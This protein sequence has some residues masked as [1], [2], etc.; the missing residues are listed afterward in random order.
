MVDRT[1]YRVASPTNFF[2]SNLVDTVEMRF[3]QG[4]GGIQTPVFLPGLVTNRT[5]LGTVDGANDYL[6]IYDA[7][8]GALKAVAPNNLP[9]GGGG[10]ANTASNTGTGVGLFR[11]KSGIDLVFKSATNSSTRLSVTTNDTHLLLDAVEAN[12][13]LANLG[14]LLGATQLHT[15]A[16]WSQT[17]DTTPDST[18]AILIVDSATASLRKVQIGN[19]PAGAGTVTHTT[20]ALTA[21]LPLTGNG[22][23]D[24]KTNTWAYFRDLADLEPGVDVQV[25]NL[26]LAGI[27]AISANG[28]VARTGS[29]TAAARTFTGTANEIDVSNGN[30]VSGNPVLSLPS[31]INLAAKASV[32][33]PTGATNDFTTFDPGA[34]GFGSNAWAAVRG[35]WRY[36]DGTASN[37]V[38]G[39]LVSDPPSNGQVPKWN[40]GG[41]ITWE[42]D[43]T[44]G[45][46]TF[47]TVAS[48]QNTTASMQ[49][50][51]GATLSVS[52]GEV[53][54]N[55]VTNATVKGAMTFP[56]NVRQT[57]N[58]G[59]DA[60][61]LNVGEYAGD[62]GTPVDGD[63]WYDGTAEQLTARING[64]NV[65]L[66][67]GGGVT[68][69][70]SST[71]NAI[72]RFD[73]TGGTTLQNSVVT[74][75]D[76]GDAVGFRIT[77]TSNLVSRAVPT[78]TN[79]VFE[80]YAVDGTLAFAVTS[81][82][83]AQVFGA[84]TGTITLGST[85]VRLTDDGD[86]AVT[87]TSLGGGSGEAHSLT[88]NLDDTANVIGVSS[89]TATSIDFASLSLSSVG[90]TLSG[91]ITLPDNI[92]QTFNPGADAAGLNVG[93]LAGDPGTP[94]NGDLWYDST[95][96]ELT[97]RINGAN[98]ALGAGGA[99][100]GTNFS[101]I[102]ITNGLERAM[103]NAGN[104]TNL[105]IN[106]GTTNS[107]WWAPSNN[108]VFLTVSGTT[109][110]GY[111]HMIEVTLVL[112]NSVNT[113]VLPWAGMNGEPVELLSAPS[114]NRLDI[115]YDG[116]RTF[117]R[118]HQAI[119]VGTG[120][121]VLA[122]NAVFYE[123]VT[124][125]K[126]TTNQFSN[127]I[128][129]TIGFGS[130]A[131][132]ATRGAWRYS[133]GVAS[134]Y[135][136]GVLVSDVPSNG[137]VP[138]YNTDGT[139]TWEADSTGGSPTFDSIASGQNTTAAMQVG[140]GATLSVSGGEVH[141][142]ILTNATVKGALTFPDNVRQTFNPGADA[143]GLNVGALAGDPGTPS[144]GDLWY[145]S[146]ANELTARI[147]GANVALGA[148]G[149]GGGTN[150][151]GLK[152]T[153]LVERFTYNVGNQ[154]N[155]TINWG[156]TNMVF[157]APS[158]NP[159]FLTVEGNTNEGWAQ[160]IHMVLV[161]SNS[162]STVVLPWTGYN[163]QPVELL[164]A[165]ST[166]ELDIVYDGQRTFIRSGQAL[167]IGSGPI[168]LVSNAVFGGTITLPHGATNDFTTF[169]PGTIGFGS[170][171]WAAVRGA[172]RYSDGTVSN[173]LVGVIVSDPPSSGQVPKWNA[174]GYFE[175]SDD[176][177]GGTTAWDAIGDATIDGSIAFAGTT[178][179]I[180]ANT[181]DTTA[182][183]QD[184]LRITISND[185][186]GDATAQRVLVVRNASATGGTTETLVALENLDNS[187]VTT[188]LSIAG[189]ST[190]A[191]TTGIDVSDAEIGTALSAGA[192][193]L[194]GTS[195]SITGS[196]GAITS[197]ATA[198]SAGQ[199]RIPNAALIN[200]R[201][202]A[203]NG[204]IGMY[205]DSTDQFVFG[206][207]IKSLTSL[208]ATAAGDPA[209]S[210]FMRLGNGDIIAWEPAPTG[211]DMALAVNASEQ[212]V[213]SGSIASMTMSASQSVQTDANTN[214]VSL[215]NTGTGNN[216][217]GTSPTIATPS[218]T[219]AIGFDDNVRQTFNPGAD[220]AGLNVGSHAGDPG[221]P[222]NGD[223]WYDSTANELTARINGATV[224]LVGGPA[225]A[226][227]ETL[228]RY[229]GTTG[230]LLQTSR[231][232]QND[233][234]MVIFTNVPS[235][236]AQDLFQFYQTNGQK[237]FYMMSN[238]TV[239]VDGH[240]SPAS[241]FTENATNEIL[242]MIN[243]SASQALATD[244]SKNLVSVPNTG[245]GNNVLAVDPTL[246]GLTVSN[247]V[248][249]STSLLAPISNGSNYVL[250][251][252]REG[253]RWIN[254]G[255]NI[256]F[257]A[258]YNTDAGGL[259]TDK[260]WFANY[261]LTNLS[262]ANWNLAFTAVTNRWKA[263]FNQGAVLPTI[264]T[265]NTRLDVNLQVNG[266]NI[267][268]SSAYC[269]WP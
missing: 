45:S 24:I 159:A 143:A 52:G 73:G 211:T 12:F 219:G 259:E 131:W 94:S 264:L 227:D 125:P 257:L 207:A 79:N 154:T 163:G 108:P 127:F 197:G 93:A 266:S 114:T 60:S 106:W 178:Q 54:A 137:Q 86:G 129:G 233:N 135:V 152:I 134:N 186:S 66:G 244:A 256:N 232:Y 191:I 76:T 235:G 165:P 225:S 245:T 51:S 46:P 200:W 241:F 262:G 202:A 92:R 28:F 36:S 69:P 55:I 198:A 230:K 95:A 103:F 181:D 48:G 149:S 67:S 164:S 26:N 180:T 126:G 25:Y 243:L 158:N 161:L 21:D 87:M 231:I 242:N 41:T 146:T 255:T 22:T 175:M 176:A 118:H 139:I 98:V 97:A 247:S 123:T 43:S 31:A 190:G 216:V 128:P 234:G 6:L 19:L 204:D 111:A 203:N 213:Y 120:P 130:N 142:N 18:D 37:Y 172:W 246:W 209:D 258:A 78:S 140:S 150:F 267:V 112:T 220:A 110:V 44:G 96:N 39:V 171:A 194:S 224:G 29:G 35:A 5:V 91:N 17:E 65:S 88:V 83:V 177:S 107:L 148:G 162:V 223:L 57:F 104:V 7:T 138:K 151:S 187:A 74:I 147:N 185:A 30:G 3:D 157:W 77:S 268:V 252:N 251:V 63:L 199:L 179:D 61:G 167:S 182:I 119:T 56:D 212:L 174:G 80:T 115:V 226:V 58:P 238:A 132:T 239:I 253:H 193:D 68:G 260:T 136:L 156:G 250:H 2:S 240:F 221:T 228:A 38:L 169:I 105:T 170:N 236:A 33:L 133:D 100:G 9:G 59:A 14:G 82:G 81:N 155:L 189:T 218:I 20:G 122:T 90:L 75:G 265:N 153:N 124:L 116:I 184:V 13:N 173:Y 10:E 217:L 210:G 117:I 208:A 99:G 201:N 11:V 188:G 195:W 269:S 145:D 215:A 53:H 160:T 102:I 85:G 144:N 84:S 42:A 113:V 249:Y 34:I 70:G 141:A 206:A 47:D 32:R 109:N 166:N 237:V 23:D 16:I 205:V 261:S 254:A 222:S 192:N 50:G 89:S 101:G 4:A 121:I 15:N 229:D 183:A 27:A 40:T 71:D 196:S 72:A 62:P 8:D 1:T 49:V 214:L 64:A 263:S 248:G 168:A